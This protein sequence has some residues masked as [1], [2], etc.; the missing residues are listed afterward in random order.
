MIFSNRSEP[1][2]L[3]YV[4]RRT[5]R[6]VSV[7]LVLVLIIGTSGWSKNRE[8]IDAWMNDLTE[9]SIE[10]LMNIEITSVSKKV[11]KLSDA[12]A[13]VF[14][15]TQEDI[16]RSGVSSIAESLRMVP[17]IQVARIDSNKWAI[18]SRG[19]NGRFANKLLVLM[20]GRSVYTPFFSG[21]FWDV[22]DTLL[23]DIDRIEVIR[24]PGASLWGAN[25]VNGV[26]NIITKAAKHTQGGLIAAGA[27]T[28]EKGFGNI[29]YGGNIGENAYYRVF[30]K[31]FNRDNSVNSLGKKAEDEWEV[32]RGGFRMDWQVS[33]QN[34]LTL[35][36]DIYHGDTNGEVRTFLPNFPFTS[37]I[38][39]ESNN[40]GGNILARWRHVSSDT[41]DME[42]QIYYD[43]EDRYPETTLDTSRNTFDI[44]FQHRFVL[45]KRQ[46]I[47]WG[48]G[49]RYTNDNVGNTFSFSFDPARRQFDL[50]SAFIHDEIL[51]VPDRLRLILGSKFEHNDFTGFEI[52][53][54]ARMIWTPNENHSIWAA[55]SRAVRTPSR[56]ENDVHA[57]TRAFPPNSIFPDSPLAFILL[58][59]D[60]GYESEELIAYEAGYRF[61]PIHQLS[62]DITGFYNKYDKLRTIEQTTPFSFVIDNKMEGETYGFELATD[63]RPAEWWYLRTAYTFLNMLLSLDSDS[64]D[65]QSEIAEDEIPNHQLSFRSF[66]DLPRNFEL[67]VWLRYVDELSAQNIDRYFTL[68]VRIG[69]K[70]LAN[71]DISLIGQNLLDNHHPEFESEILD[72]P[73]VEIERSV[74]GKITWWF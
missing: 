36:G 32:L 22:Q 2:Y 31:Y 20:D 26:I 56:A 69:W 34:S 40:S 51:L 60:N 61:R 27:G 17:G 21:V 16:R 72:V 62:V 15:I 12:A 30:A 57:F 46:E 52:Q 9:L 8:N 13:A 63:W 23:E 49:Y 44:D 53:P 28:E 3:K 41:S 19:F 55:I 29:R 4:S 10:D 67:D 74:Y 18:T 70:P 50:F 24:G 5:I 39:E 11:Q 47:I 25:A 14:V 33:H 58:Q 7:S 54:T 37:I 73:P 65:I 1:D 71:L 38:K 42:L 43:R 35:Q 59:G 6:T 45:G 64:R 66:M 48:L 68:D